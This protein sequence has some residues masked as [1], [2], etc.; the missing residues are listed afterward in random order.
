[1][2]QPLE[3]AQNKQFLGREDELRSLR[4][5]DASAE[6]SLVVVYGRR[7]VGKTEL[8]EQAYRERRPLKFEGIEGGDTARQLEQ[9]VYQLSRYAGDGALQK[10][11]FTR[12]LEFFDYLATFV[13]RG[14]WTL[15]FEE[16][17]WLAAYGEE[18]VADLKHAWD[19]ALRRNPR[20]VVV[21]CGSAPSFML[22]KV[23]RSR[24]LYGRV[25]KEIRLA[26]F[27]FAD[28]AAF[29]GAR[30]STFDLFEAQLAL[31]GIPEYLK[32][33]RTQ[34]ST[35]LA[36]CTHAF[37]PDAHLLSE[38][39]RIFVSSLAKS[40]H[41]RGIV[42]FLAARRGATRA[43]IAAHCGIKAGGTLSSVLEDLELCGFIE[44]VVPYDKEA[45]SKLVRYQIADPYLQF[46]YRFI[47]PQRR[48]IESGSFV[49]RPTAALPLHHYQQWLGYV[50]ERWCRAQHRRIA[51]LLGF[52]AVRYRSGAWIER[53]GGDGFQFDLVFD[54]AD[55]V[56]TLCEIKYTQA[57]VGPAAAKELAQ[58]TEALAI[59]R[60][61][62]VE[63][64]L[65]S[66]AGVEPEVTAG[67]GFDRVLALGEL[68]GRA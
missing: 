42:E 16:V 59:P 52:G 44:G 4:A 61:T 19:N 23:L 25:A 2:L 54:R 6:A 67:G 29:V 20:L 35:Y 68:L 18:F 51:E 31:G 64:V 24:A 22:G 1:M 9:A 45:T 43:E 66:A 47:A 41:Y 58:R 34:S 36:L 13:E 8:V 10:L 60:R 27:S 50:F 17:Q 55:H 56:L 48:A 15:Y 3:I 46:Y 57:P 39:E 49:G 5:V 28:T 26:P 32:L 33:V 62:T 65:I 12:W 14:A 21:L 7:R 53:G 63:R 11:R 38:C 40:V 30:R 37:L